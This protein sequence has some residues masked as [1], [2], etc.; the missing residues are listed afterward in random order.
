[1]FEAWRGANPSTPIK[2]L[3]AVLADKADTSEAGYESWRVTVKQPGLDLSGMAA[4]AA[5]KAVKSAIM[6]VSRQA[7][8][9][10]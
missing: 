1:M 8:A 6:Q 5:A 9:D 7:A 10:V 3:M 4:A 2:Q